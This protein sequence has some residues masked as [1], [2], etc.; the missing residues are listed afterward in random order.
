MTLSVFT[1]CVC[2]TSADDV[3]VKNKVKLSLIN[4][5]NSFVL[6]HLLVKGKAFFHL[7]KAHITNIVFSNQQP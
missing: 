2:I 5:S 3:S 6:R 7:Q 1:V 4:N